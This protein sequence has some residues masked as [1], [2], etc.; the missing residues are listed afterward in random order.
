MSVRAKQNVAAALIGLVA[1]TAVATTAHFQPSL[2]SH[3]SGASATATPDSNGWQLTPDSN[4]WQ[5]LA[6]GNGWQTAPGASNGWQATPAA[7]NG[8]Q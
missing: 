6:D 7:G 2:A 3:L 5:T 1:A 4:G 8:W